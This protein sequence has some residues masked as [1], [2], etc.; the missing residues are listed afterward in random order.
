MANNGVTLKVVGEG[1]TQEVVE[2]VVNNGVT[3]KVVGGG[4]NNDVSLKVV[5]GVGVVRDSVNNCSHVSPHT[6]W[7]YNP[8]SLERFRCS[9]TYPT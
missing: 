5:G 3:L 8:L 1:G 7:I 9:S 6:R 2:G 4:G